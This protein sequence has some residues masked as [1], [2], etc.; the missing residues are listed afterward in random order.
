MSIEPTES[1]RAA[2]RE[3][4]EMERFNFE[5]RNLPPTALYRILAKHHA[6]EREHHWTPEE[7]TLKWVANIVSIAFPGPLG[8]YS[9]ERILSILKKH[10][11]ERKVRNA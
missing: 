7:Q 2:A 6:E 5:G 8:S 11:E 9:P 3:I 10:S 4:N 1:D